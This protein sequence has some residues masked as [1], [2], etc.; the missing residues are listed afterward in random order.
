MTTTPP[1]SQHTATASKNTAPNAVQIPKQ[2]IFAMKIKHETFFVVL[3]GISITRDQYPW[4]R[5]T[6]PHK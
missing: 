1:E 5:L 3:V 6:N 2:K 4:F